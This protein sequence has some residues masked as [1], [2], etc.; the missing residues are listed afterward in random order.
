MV[1]HTLKN[2]VL[3]ALLFLIVAPASAEIA[4]RFTPADTTLEVGST[5]RLSVVCDDTLDLRTIELFVEFDPNVVASVSGGPGSL[6]TD[7]GFSLFQGFELSEPNEWHGYCVVMGAGL[8]V[9]S[10]GELF[11]WE[12]EG[13]ANGVSPIITASLVLIAPGSIQVQDVTLD[14]TSIIV[15]NDP[16]PVPTDPT[17]GHSLKCYPNPFNPLTKISYSLPRAENVRLNVYRID[18]GLVRT[19]V[20]GPRGPGNHQVIWNGRDDAGRIQPSGLFF[21]RI[22]SGPYSLV[23]KMTLM[24]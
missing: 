24:K 12:F 9:V 7:S 19:L 4:L 5:A 2:T 3:I 20:N 16:S 11:Y 13:L 1:T 6:F 15:G 17:L 21:Y 22:D 8:F 14:S 10:P 18:G 23:R